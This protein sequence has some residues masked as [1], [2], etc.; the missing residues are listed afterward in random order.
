MTGASGKTI[1]SSQT[2]LEKLSVKLW[3]KSCEIVL[4]N[5]NKITKIT[6]K[7]LSLC[8]QG[9]LKFEILK[10][11]TKEATITSKKLKKY[12]KDI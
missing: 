4:K 10:D 3:D 1:K 6:E 2:K 11:G 9:K 8:K 7:I 12:I 5:R